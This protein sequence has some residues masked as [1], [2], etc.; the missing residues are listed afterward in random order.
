MSPRRTPPLARLLSALLVALAAAVGCS[1]ADEPGPVLPALADE[2]P[3]RASPQPDKASGGAAEKMPEKKPGQMPVEVE[4]PPERP[5]PKPSLEKPYV[6]P[7]AV[8]RWF[9]F[10]LTRLAGER[11]AVSP[12]AL[13]RQGDKATSCRVETTPDPGVVLPA[14]EIYRRACG[15]VVIVGG[16]G[17]RR[18]EHGPRRTYCACGF[19]LNAGGVIATN[20][21]LLTMFQD[22]QAVGVM[23]HD[24]RV[25]AIRKVL[26]ADRHSD[27]AVLQIDAHDLL[28]LPVAA[29]VPI[30]ARVWCLS[31]PAL[32]GTKTQNAFYAFTEGIVSGQY[33]MHLAGPQPVDVLTVTTDYAV[34]S[35]GGPILNQHG[36]AVGMTCQTFPIFHDERQFDVQMIWKLA[37]PMS[38]LLRLISG[39]QPPGMNA[40]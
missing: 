16:L 22:M 4:K 2:P 15:S 28:P 24:G 5:P 23:T 7:D 12:P 27:L 8:S 6:D 26:A 40:N 25:F 9:A 38:T 3:A 21:H 18:K 31:H 35:S 13:A 19:V 17:Q 36:A 34:G 20:A 39:P 14:E 1:P 29:D 10:E 30:G 32:N 33:R 11:S 37:R